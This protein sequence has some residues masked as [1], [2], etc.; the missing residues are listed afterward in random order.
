MPFVSTRAGRLFY[1]QRG[2]GA[3]VVMLHAA[4][5]DHRDFDL[6]AGQLAGRYRTIAVDWPGHGRSDPVGEG[7]GA[8]A[9]LFAGVLADLVGRLGLGPAVLVGNSVGGFAAA[10]LAL[11]HPDWV[12]GLVLVNTAGFTRQTVASRA[13]CRVLGSPRIARRLLPRLVAGYMKPRGDHDRAIAGRVQARA[14]TAEGA[15]VAAGLWRSF[16]APAF[17][18][19]AD[20]PRLAA[21]VL[22]CG[23][24]GTSSCRWRPGGR[25]MRPSP[26]RNSIRSA[27]GMWFS[28]RIRAG[29]WNS[30]GPSSSRR[31]GTRPIS[32]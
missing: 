24:P 20:G 15:R 18:L 2:S 29:S 12:A 25:R 30:P 8:D 19:R 27:P 9:F 11:D 14:G 10:R 22:W 28:R 31:A 13:S 4:L 32:H 6:V 5:H 7:R 26:V 17:A 1:E 3:P 23:A 21:P 16:A